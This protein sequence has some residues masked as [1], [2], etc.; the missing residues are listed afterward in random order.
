MIPLK[1]QWNWIENWNKSN[2][3]WRIKK[4]SI[5]IYIPYSISTLTEGG[6]IGG[7]TS[8]SEVQSIVSYAIASNH[9]NHLMSVVPFPPQPFLRST[10]TLAVVLWKTQG[11]AGLSVT[12]LGWG[13]LEQYR[14]PSNRSI[15]DRQALSGQLKCME[16]ILSDNRPSKRIKP[17]RTGGSWWKTLLN[18]YVFFLGCSKKWFVDSPTGVCIWTLLSQIDWT[19]MTWYCSFGKLDFTLFL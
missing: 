3:L 18:M 1:K 17:F 16:L 12:I 10:S 2:Q 15:P 6:C 19:E 14:R 8:T 9:N 4:I 11:S 5:C 7:R 13:G